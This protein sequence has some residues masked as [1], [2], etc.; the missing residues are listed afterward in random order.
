MVN[1]KCPEIAIFFDL[2]VE[3]ARGILHGFMHYVRLN[4]PW[5]VNFISKT[6]SDVAPSSLKNWSGDGIM[7]HIPDQETYQEILTKQCSIVLLAGEN[8]EQILFN[9]NE[10]LM[11]NLQYPYSPV[12]IRCNNKAIGQM[13]SDFFLQKSYRNFAY[14]SY[15]KRVC[16]CFERRQAFTEILS[17]HKIPV[18]CF[19]MP[20]EA[21]NDWF[22]QRNRMSDWLLT[23]PKPIAVFAANDFIGRQVLEV[24]QRA[25]IPVPYEVSVLGV[26]NDLPVCEMSYP[27]LSSIA[28]DWNQ[29]GF[30]AAES[31]HRQ[32]TGKEVSRKTYEPIR[33]IS[34]GSTEFFNIS[35]NVVVRILELIRINRGENIRVTDIVR[36]LP[37]S[38]R[39]AQERFKKTIGHSIMEEIKQVR[40]KNICELIQNTNLSF[41]EIA[42]SFGFE[43]ANHLGQIFKK[44]F[45]LTMGE[46]RKNFKNSS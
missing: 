27:S 25:E 15:P 7:A 23:L 44:E 4:Q 9:R 46:Y 14:V 30:L 42:L 20:D 2:S 38:A 45:N 22:T 36:S 13:A 41:N 35:D 24:C 29:A 6:V 32:M 28:I 8:D 31:L 10:N 40:M 19:S 26:D 11:P 3:S 39:R 33:V 17:K 21:G 12:F 16:W 5:N 34:R 18:H 37:I 43:N 1:L